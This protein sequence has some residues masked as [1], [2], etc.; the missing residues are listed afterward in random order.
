MVFRC[1]RITKEQERRRPFKDLTDGELK[2]LHRKLCAQITNYRSNPG[3][4]RNFLE[5][6]TK[7]LLVGK[8]FEARGMES[9]VDR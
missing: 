1:G 7:R 6:T 3:A 9:P 2:V 4:G 8:E 5:L